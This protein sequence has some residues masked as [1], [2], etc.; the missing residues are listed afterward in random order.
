M[1]NLAQVRP[2][3]HAGVSLVLMG[4]IDET[5]LGGLLK[6]SKNTGA[7]SRAG[8]AL[9]TRS[10]SLSRYTSETELRPSSFAF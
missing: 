4:D 7:Y 10:L 8:D 5:M 3:A 2:G 1:K 9:L 6:A